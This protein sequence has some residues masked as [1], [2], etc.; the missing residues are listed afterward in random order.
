MALAR[1]V[2]EFS[3]NLADARSHEAPSVLAVVG[4]QVGGGEVAAGGGGVVGWAEMLRK[5]QADQLTTDGWRLVCE[6]QPVEK[7][8]EEDGGAR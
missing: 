3:L 5:S 7:E 1:K 2:D 6:S 4:G 8:E